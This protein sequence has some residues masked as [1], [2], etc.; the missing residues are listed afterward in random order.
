M[1]YCKLITRM[2]FFFLLIIGDPYWMSMQVYL[3]DDALID[4]IGGL[5]DPRYNG[6]PLEGVTLM[7]YLLEYGVKFAKQDRKYL[8][9]QAY[10][11][12]QDTTMLESFWSS[13]CVCV[14]IKS[15]QQK[16]KEIEL[17]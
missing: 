7:Q 14:C 8:V 3:F 16:A 1:N 12:P 5:C 15:E 11:V 9:Q 2:F 6:T 10:P 13:A 17:S 4:N